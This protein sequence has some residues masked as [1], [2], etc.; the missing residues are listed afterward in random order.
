MIVP[1]KFI[2]KLQRMPRIQFYDL[3]CDINVDKLSAIENYEEEEWGDQS[4]PIKKLCINAFANRMKSSN[5]ERYYLYD[6]AFNKPK[7]RSQGTQTE[8]V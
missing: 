7:T 4:K 1:D 3:W 5:L 8:E 6:T 2:L